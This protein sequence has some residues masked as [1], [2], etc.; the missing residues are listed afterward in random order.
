MFDPALNYLTFQHMDQMFATRTVAAGGDIWQLPAKLISIEEGDYTLGERTVGLQEALEATA[1]NALVVV[2]DGN[3]VFE[4]YRNGS[5][6]NT[7]FLTF[8]VAKS[9]V[10]TLIGLAL[11]DGP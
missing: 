7:R 10:S 6:E 2:K 5:D 3:I 1:A 4:S 9:Y 11:A 8:S